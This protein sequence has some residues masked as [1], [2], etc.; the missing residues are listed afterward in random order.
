MSKKLGKML[1]ETI[2]S[3]F[4]KPATSS[5]PFK[6]REIHKHYNGKVAY[7]KEKCVGCNMCV[8]NCPAKAIFITKIADKQ[9]EATLHLDRCIFCSQC[10]IS[11]KF[12]AL[13]NTNEFE[14]ATGDKSKLVV[15]L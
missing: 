3:L 4:K 2:S 8:R 7:I 15:K 12:G 11:C 1:A 10:V 14:L 6:K 9:F 5:Y 13:K